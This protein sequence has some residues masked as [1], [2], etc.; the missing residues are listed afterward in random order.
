MCFCCRR[1][2]FRFFLFLPLLFILLLTVSCKDDGNTEV[3]R[4]EFVNADRIRSAKASA[5][6]ADTV[7]VRAVGDSGK[8]M[9]GIAVR[10]DAKTGS[11]LTFRLAEDASFQPELV[12]ETD[13][14]GEI[15]LQVKAGKKTG[16]QYIEAVALKSNVRSDLRV[17]AGLEISGA[18][19]ETACGEKLVKPFSVTLTDAEGKPIAGTEVGFSMRSL[20]S[21]QK[22]CDDQV[23]LT[24]ADGK[25]Q[26][27][28][29]VG[30]DTGKYLLAVNIHKQEYDTFIV[31]EMGLNL[32][33]L[34]INVFGGLAIFIFGMKLMSDGLHI[35]AGEKMKTLLHFFSSNRLVAILAGTL[36]TT[37]LQSSSASTVMV[38]GFVN[39]GLLSLEQSIGIIFGANIGKAVVTQLVAFNMSAVIMPCII[40]GLL[41]LFISWQRLRGWGETFLGFGFLFMGMGQMSAQL[42][43]LGEFPSFI[44]F[45]RTFQCMPQAG[46]SVPFWALLGAIGIGIIVTMVVQSS[47][48][49]TGIVIV[50]CGSG[51]LDIYASIAIVLGANI[52]TTITA[53]LA[54]IPANR[55]AKQ[56]AMAHTLFNVLGVLIVL[57][58]FWIRLPGAA[59]PLFP[60]LV[61]LLTPGNIFAEVPENIPHYIVNAHMYFNILTTLILF[62]FIPLLAK[63]CQKV[64][65]IGVKK[66]KFTNLEPHL[67]DTPSLA[68]EQTGVALRK[69]L[70]KSWKMI[71]I[72]TVKCF[73]PGNTDEEEFASLAKKEEKIDQL[74]YEITAYLTQIMSRHLNKDQAAVIPLLM[75]CTNDA[76][77]IADHTENMTALT[78][79]LKET[80]TTLSE[81][82]IEELNNMHTMLKEQASCTIS[83]LTQYSK[84]TVRTA[85]EN[86][87]NIEVAAKVF[88]D[89]HIHRLGDQICDPLTGVIFIEFIA[90][91]VKVSSHLVNIAERAERIGTSYTN[92]AAEL[93]KKNVEMAK[94]MRLS[95]ATE[96][97][98]EDDADDKI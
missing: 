9:A 49:T 51:L 28:P 69:M 15:H 38:I 22:T 43:P 65:P 31:R 91:L 10:I 33:K 58:F 90:E 16:D 1:I 41:T 14:A 74:Q 39:A 87:K 78:I 11:E 25:A 95:I 4:L 6:F 45:F 18:D 71:D 19:Q 61:N 27:S 20:G 85:F 75:H 44:N 60:E 79:R 82:A 73:I 46:G 55:V 67:L 66:I 94:T 30:A 2:T 96:N 26:F 56:A 70:K 97:I 13:A 89:N 84:D 7:T 62:A 5:E 93:R 40:L 3:K 72:A 32:P 77:R 21:G 17:I 48:P 63:F 83:A 52:G 54:S 81:N 35:A 86:A 88:E 68:L 29:V 57:P 64:L 98:L 92:I 76:E 59:H 36:V 53:Q 34:L 80:G 50:L 47:F 23:L 24:D 42:K 37:V 8:P 12:A